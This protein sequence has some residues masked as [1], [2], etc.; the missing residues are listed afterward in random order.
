MPKTKACIPVAVIN[1]FGAVTVAMLSYFQHVR[2][3]K[4]SLYLNGY[5]F[6]SAILDIAQNRTL[7]IRPNM[8]ALA[9]VSA[10]AL[11]AKLMLLFLEEVPKNNVRVNTKIANEAL[12]GIFS[13]GLF[14]W[15]NS[16]FLTGIKSLLSA[17]DINGIS[18]KLDSQRLL[19]A[20]EKNW[21]IGI[22]AV[23]LHIY[24]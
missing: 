12:V 21:K 7:W 9:A 2:S 23:S 11:V 5:L 17:H 15:L 8:L 1:I 20:L 18:D 16:L 14:C 24:S 3:E 13:R 22:D 19:A 10:V 6:L 4:P